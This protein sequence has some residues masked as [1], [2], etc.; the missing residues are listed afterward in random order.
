MIRRVSA[1]F[2]GNP[3]LIQG[4]NTFLPQGYRIE[5]G[6][7]EDPNAIRVTTPQG[8]TVSPMGRPIDP[9]PE[10][11]SATEVSASAPTDAR[12][13][14]RDS[15][16]AWSQQRGTD[17]TDTYLSPSSRPQPISSFNHALNQSNP[18]M[19]P[20]DSSV[21]S[22]EPASRVNAAMLAHQQEQHGVSQLQSAV[23]AQGE[24]MNR[25]SALSP[26]AD[27]SGQANGTGEPQQAGAADK[28]GPVEFN[29]AISYVNKIKVGKPFLGDAFF[30]ANYDFRRIAS[31]HNL[32]ST[33]NFWK[34]F[35]PI[36]ESRSPFRTSMRK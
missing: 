6:T 15:A 33:N 16:G 18:H 12:S 31:L 34:S 26:L 1:L 29:H 25:A 35:K 19:S 11:P 30:F 21:G 13:F 3:D 28:R 27:S 14:D 8:T 10:H 9:P 20:V 23:A 36:S 22:G 24:A 4:F 17:Q 2:Q 32:R 7:A 5:C